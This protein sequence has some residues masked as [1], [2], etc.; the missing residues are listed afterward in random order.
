M[1]SA[2]N[3]A[4]CTTRRC[5]AGCH[6]P[7]GAPTSSTRFC[8]ASA[9]ARTRFT[10]TH[11]STRTR[12]RGHCTRPGV[13]PC[14][15]RSHRISAKRFNF[16]RPGGH[17][18]VAGRTA[19]ASREGGRTG[20][21]REPRARAGVGQA[22]GNNTNCKT[23][24]NRLSSTNFCA[25]AP[26]NTLAD[27]SRGESRFLWHCS[28]ARAPARHRRAVAARAAPAGVLRDVDR[29]R[30]TGEVAAMIEAVREGKVINLNA[31]KNAAARTC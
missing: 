27:R 4:W 19:R 24:A 18:G 26:R 29:V 10:P 1:A 23:D 8:A 15:R 9:A 20:A 6:A 5:C 12:T 2:A 17:G 25:T 13:L 21:A 30:A 16:P 22:P 7:P 14:A 31:V 28:G 3:A 11:L